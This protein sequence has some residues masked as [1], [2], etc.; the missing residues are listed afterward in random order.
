MNSNN[1]TSK[2]NSNI[3]G[4]N[5]ISMSSNNNTSNSNMNSK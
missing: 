5:N 1:N 2:M 3:N 4:C